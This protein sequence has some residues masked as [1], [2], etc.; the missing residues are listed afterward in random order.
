MRR[1]SRSNYS[2][3]GPAIVFALWVGAIVGTFAEQKTPPPLKPGSA[4]LVV[5]PDT[6]GYP[7]RRPQIFRAMMQW[8]ANQQKARNIAGV[9]HV[10]DVTNNNTKR[11]WKVARECFDLVEG[12]IPY[13]LSAGNHD[14][15]GTPGRL[16]HMNEFFKVADLEKKSEFGDVYEAGKLENH[17]QIIEI[18][19]R[20]WLILSL[21]MGPR[22]AVIKWGNEVLAKHKE[23][24]AIVLTHGYL[25]YDN[26]RYNHLLG[27]QRATPYNFYG[28]GADGEQLWDG[29]VRKHP[30]VMM[31]VCGHLS[32][33]FVGYRA[34]ESDYGN[35]VHQMMVDYEK[36]PGGGMG[37]LRLLEFFP[38][39]ETVQV[40]TYSPVTGGKN[41]RDPKL[42]DF[43]F[44][45]RFATR[46]QPRRLA[47]TPAT[48]LSRPPQNRFS[49]DGAKGA[50]IARDSIGRRSGRLR[51]GAL[52]DGEGKLVLSGE[53][54]AELPGRL[55]KGKTELS[56]ELWFT[57]TVNTYKWSAPV[58][59]G[60]ADDWFTYVFRTLTTHRAEIAVDR[61]N[62]DIQQSV[63]AKS[64]QEMHVVVTYDADGADGKA[65]LSYY[66]DGELRGKMPTGLKLADVSE[67]QNRLGPF[68][69]VFDEFRIYDYP[70][71]PGEVANNYNAGSDQLVVG[72]EVRKK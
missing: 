46:D 42:E 63:P 14:Y 55:I 71:T 53:A 54:V 7:A 61:H 66:R 43:A 15:D 25:Y 51:D 37:F 19:G 35:L 33:G 49:F 10:G 9:L 26:Q 59:L 39:R 58:R 31:V 3:P 60:S 18:H 41:P 56:F 45:L 13:V 2:L 27:K 5:L 30:N 8:V 34:D 22:K 36:L 24:P 50:K 69:G 12:K 44:K 38:D 11:E 23:H 20:R 57:P 48:P 32:S 52:L 62:E 29:L 68:A 67:D 4:T 16:T 21:E 70:L 64:G 1:R 65:L 40:R 28:E 72:T 47:K 6:E 17:Y